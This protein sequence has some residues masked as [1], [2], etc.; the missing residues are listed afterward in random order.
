MEPAEPLDVPPVPLPLFPLLP[1]QA[2]ASS[3]T[4]ATATPPSSRTVL[5][6]LI[7]ISLLAISHD[8]RCL[9]RGS[10]DRAGPAAAVRESTGLRAG[11][12]GAATFANSGG[13]D[14]AVL[15]RGALN[16]DG[17]AG[18]EVLGRAAL[19]DLHP[20]GSVRG[21]LDGL[22]VAGLQIDRLPDDLL[23]GADG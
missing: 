3:R 12:L 15:V 22:S 6:E 20:G 21:D 17:R 8:F 18:L 10:A 14:R 16:D 19:G 13:G 23:Y 2:P 5:V 7:T 9:G 1:P 4:P 11:A